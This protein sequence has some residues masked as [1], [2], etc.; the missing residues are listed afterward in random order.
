MYPQPYPVRYLASLSP[1]YPIQFAISYPYAYRTLSVV[2]T[3]SVS[4]PLALTLP[5]PI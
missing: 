5:N 2:L 1:L 4:L 3:L